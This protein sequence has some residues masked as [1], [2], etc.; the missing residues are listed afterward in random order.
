MASDSPEEI[1]R[2]KEKIS[3]NEQLNEQDVNTIKNKQELLDL[4]VKI[5]TEQEKTI[6]Y[7]DKRINKLKSEIET[8]DVLAK[9][10]GNYAELTRAKDEAAVISAEKKFKADV[11]ALNNLRKIEATQEEIEKQQ[12]EVVKS[13]KDYN[14]Q[15]NKAKDNARALGQ[16]NALAKLLGIDEANKNSLTYQIFNNPGKVFEGFNEQIQ[17]AG[18]FAKAISASILTKV[19]EATVATFFAMDE[20]YSSFAAA[21]GAAAAYNNVITNTTRG[22]TALGISFKE[23]GKATTDLYTNLN[24]FTSLNTK[25]QESLVVT[26]GKLERLG[27]SGADTAKS[28]ATLSTMMGVS[29][30]QAAQTTEKFAAMGQAI[31]VASKQMISDFIA[32]KEQLAVFGNTMDKTFIK[33]E[34]QSKATGVAINDLLNLANKFDTFE[35]AANQVAKLNAVLGGP[36]LSAMSIVEAT[37]P[38]ERI[39]MLRQAVNNA[40]VSFESMSYYEKKA[41]MEAGGFKSVEE[42]QRVLS[43]SAGQYADQLQKQEANQKTLNDA[44]ERAIPVKEKLTLLMSNL[45]IAIEP[46]VTG[47]SWFVSL[48]AEFMDNGGRYLVW[49][50]MAY[51]AM[52]LL[53][54]GFT[55]LRTSIAAAGGIMKFFGTTIKG[56]A[57]D[58]GKAVEDTG[59]AAEKGSKSI[60]TS[61]IN[62]AKGA[63]QSIKVFLTT[64]AQGI[65]SFIMTLSSLGP[66]AMAALP[67]VLIF[68]LISIALLALG[69]AVWMVGKGFK[70]MFDGLA[71]IIKEAIKAPAAFVALAG[72][73]FI[74]AA[75]IALLSLNPLMWIGMA[76][77]TATLL[78]IAGALALMDT[79]KLYNFRVT[80]EKIVEVSEPKSISGFE[81]FS[82]KFE[83]VAEATAKIEVAKTQTFTQMLTATQN[84]AQSM[85]INQTVVVKIGSQQ[86]KGVIES[87]VNDKM[88]NNATATTAGG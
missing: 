86:F 74:L 27:I 16:G 2:I 5:K 9:E 12:N 39:N 35:G 41:I 38:T 57:T 62:L 11:E 68:G 1:Q 76:V 34:T 4:F 31:G 64:A 49:V 61:I 17:N 43:M 59:K 56:T 65:R 48:L 55:T 15:I 66:G 83:A 63:G 19:Q 36:F 82:D 50:Y 60:A 24:T 21:T 14:D 8:L 81:K 44:I 87:V 45:A 79:D 53:T 67:A 77:L 80:M 58:T 88:P 18:G 40:G 6:E 20:A 13:A 3:L 33:L 51:K 85:S 32:V 47:I 10:T 71:N 37:D 84:L 72:S 22:N 42:A 26:A 7:Y 30:T 78:G 46:V 28:I 73:I 75:A 70:L 69:A 29:E 52:S 23:A 54:L 25:A